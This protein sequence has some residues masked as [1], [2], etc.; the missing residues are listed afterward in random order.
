MAEAQ[1]GTLSG[2]A[3][4]YDK[5]GNLKGEFNFS[6]QATA[7]QAQKV[8]EALNHGSDTQHNN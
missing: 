1:S 5:D 3:Q 4:V 7:E 6:T 8:K 2:T